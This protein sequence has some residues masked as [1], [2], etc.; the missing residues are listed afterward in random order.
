MVDILSALSSKQCM[1]STLNGIIMALQHINTFKALL[2]NIF[3]SVYNSAY[4][5]LKAL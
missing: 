3:S 4:T 2:D 5:A 1:Y